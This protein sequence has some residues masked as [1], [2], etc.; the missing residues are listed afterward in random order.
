MYRLGLRSSH[1]NDLY[2]CDTRS[3]EERQL[4]LAWNAMEVFPHSAS[5]FDF[6]V[7]PR[8]IHVFGVYT[9]F[10]RNLKVWIWLTSVCICSGCRRGSNHI[11]NSSDTIY[12][13]ITKGHFVNLNSLQTIFLADRL[14]QNFCLETWVRDLSVR[15]KLILVF[16]TMPKTQI[17]VMV[18]FCTKDLNWGQDC[19]LMSRNWNWGQ[20]CH[21][22]PRN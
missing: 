2:S 8:V 13:V 18:A 5:W 7:N 20:G 16:P 12:L 6:I 10:V 21:F 3:W 11:S 4:Q 19:N 22:M 17:R 9:R 15:P 14:G 1:C